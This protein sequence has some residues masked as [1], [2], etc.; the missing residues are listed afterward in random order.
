MNRKIKTIGAALLAA[1]MCASLAGCGKEETPKIKNESD[2][3]KYLD[4]DFESDL[5]SFANNL[6]GGGASSAPE[7]SAPKEVKIEMT[8][9]IKNAALNSGLVQLN[10]DIFQRGGYETVADFVEKWKDSYDITYTCIQDHAVKEVGTYDECRDYLLEYKDEFFKE[11]RVLG[12]RWS[13]QYSEYYYYLTLT[14]KNNGN[15]VKAYVANVTSPDEKITLDKAIVLEIEPQKKGLDFVTPEWIPT[16]F[17][18]RDF[19][20]KY[21]SENSNYTAKT[22]PDFIESNGII[23]NSKFDYGKGSLPGNRSKDNFNTYWKSG[24][25]YG[26]YVLGETNLFGAKPYYYFSFKIDPN[27]DKVDYVSCTLEYFI[28]D[29]T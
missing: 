22:L 1:A 23:K 8:D 11:T 29:E 18:D 15:A 14:P 19:K 7:T 6:E 2:L 16:G 9:E 21:E 17:N 4:G 28:K 13:T 10:N 24:D 27:T 20:D 26:C 5:E 3:E 25:N 12:F